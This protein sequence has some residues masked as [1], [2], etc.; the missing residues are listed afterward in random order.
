MCIPSPYYHADQLQFRG[1]PIGID[2]LRVDKLTDLERNRLFQAFFRYELISKMRDEGVARLVASN[3]RMFSHGEA[4]ALR[5][6]DHY[7]RDLYGA[8]FAHHATS[9]LPE[10]PAETAGEKR[11]SAPD[12]GIRFS[13][14]TWFSP[15]AFTKHA[16][17]QR[18]ISQQLGLVGFSL[19]TLLLSAPR[20]DR[21]CP[22]QLMAKIP[23]HLKISRWT[24]GLAT[25]E[26][27]EEGGYPCPLNDRPWDDWSEVGQA[28]RGN[29]SIAFA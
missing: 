14:N 3:V 5:C 15:D 11:K 2:I 12:G 7:M 1:Q 28:L 25:F 24:R 9:Q 10:I 16:F 21:G 17:P 26:I 18:P 23:M 4:E 6:V 29:G 8:V 27:F 19:M 20:D 22:M 13:N